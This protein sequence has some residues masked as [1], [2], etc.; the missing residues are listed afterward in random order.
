MGGPEGEGPLNGAAEF[1]P[2]DGAGRRQERDVGEVSDPCIG[3]LSRHRKRVEL[4]GDV[5][6]NGIEA[7]RRR[8]DAGEAE[9]D[10]SPVTWF[11]GGTPPNW[12]ASP[13]VVAVVLEDDNVQLAEEIGA[14]LLTAAMN[15]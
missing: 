6:D 4:L 8:C 3:P 14:G 1:R 13:L 10:E 15:P 2:V 9:S 12:Q 11:I 7:Y 5:G